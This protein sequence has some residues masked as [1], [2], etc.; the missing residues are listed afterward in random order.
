MVYQHGGS[1]GLNWHNRTRT[2]YVAKI[3]FF[4]I[5]PFT[6]QINIGLGAGGEGTILERIG[7]K[8]DVGGVCAASGGRRKGPWGSR[9][10]TRP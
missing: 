2:I 5:T 3:V 10:L 6:I 7:V 1:F 9:A 4:F 8:R